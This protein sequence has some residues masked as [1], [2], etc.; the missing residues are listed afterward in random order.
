MD[1]QLEDQRRDEQEV[2]QKL[3]PWPPRR[4]LPSA[5]FRR[6]LDLDVDGHQVHPLCRPAGAP[7]GT[8]RSFGELVDGQVS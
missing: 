3:A 1:E 7:L 4:L 6:S 8:R 2:R 5:I